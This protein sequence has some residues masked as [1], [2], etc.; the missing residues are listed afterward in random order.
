[1]HMCCFEADSLCDD[2]LNDALL[3]LQLPQATL[4]LFYPSFVPLLS[5]RSL[6][7]TDNTS[8]RCE[9]HAVVVKA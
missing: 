5:F 4:S 8:N 9:R 3:L 6:L 7:Y 1:M 2:D